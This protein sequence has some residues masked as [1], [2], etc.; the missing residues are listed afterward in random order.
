MTPRHQRHAEAI[1]ATI[2]HNRG[3][4]TG[5]LRA[6]E[7]TLGLLT[8]LASK[9]EGMSFTELVEAAELPPSTAHRL[10]SA[11][12]DR[13]LV[14]ETP[15]G[16]S[17][18]GP[19]T[20]V[21]AGAFLDGL[22]LRT[23]ARPIMCRF[24]EGSGETCHLG[25]L[26]SAHIVYIE[27]VDSPQRVR[28][29][30]HVGGT[31]PALTTALGRA[32]LAYSPSSL[33]QSTVSACEA[34]PGFTVDTGKLAGQLENVRENGFSTD[35][36]ENEPGICCL[37]AP[38]FDHTGRAVA[39]ISVSTPASRFDR[40]QVANNGRWIRAT[41]DKITAALG[42]Q[43]DPRPPRVAIRDRLSADGGAAK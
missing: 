18:L 28:M 23:E 16:L 7:R 14:R 6:V 2:D 19:A 37:G 42:W 9:P 33:L 25:V 12:R 35:I 41:A 36:E 22:D 8:I 32:I 5:G 39:A 15:H 1:T 31:N 11:L 10:L 30:S 38:I 13:H 29:V 34:M 3:G 17:A 26:A 43:D 20:I 21:L 24:V 40:D 4:G 27:K